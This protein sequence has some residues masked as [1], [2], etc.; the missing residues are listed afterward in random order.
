MADKNYQVGELVTFVS[1]EWKG[2]SGVVSWLITKD[3]AGY[4]LV[5][6]EGQVAGIPTSFEE[7]VPADE[8]AKGYTQLAYQLI[9]LSSHLI[10]TTIM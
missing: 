9:K 1:G 4:V 6:S 8:T 2:F 3:G 5:C 10:E 7:I